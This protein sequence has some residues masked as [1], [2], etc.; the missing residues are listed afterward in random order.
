L[1]ASLGGPYSDENGGLPV[2]SLTARAWVSE[3]VAFTQPQP[4]SGGYAKDNAGAFTDAA[5]AVLGAPADFS[6]NA[7]TYHVAS[8]GNGGSIILAFPCAIHDGAG[9]DLAVFENGFTDES[10]TSGTVRE[11][12]TNSFAFAE[13]AFVDVGTTTS[14]WARFPVTCLNSSP[15]FNLNNL[16]EN[17]F[18]SQD[19]TLLDGIAGKHAFDRGTSFDL[20]DLSGDPAVLDGRVD[21]DNIRFVRL[22]DVVGDGSATDSE[23]RPIYDPFFSTSLGYPSPAAPSA[24]DGFDLRGVAVLN[25]TEIAI[26]TAPAG[27]EVVWHGAGKTLYQPQV[28]TDLMHWMDLGAAVTGFD[29]TLCVTSAMAGTQYHRVER[30]PVQP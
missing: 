10:D 28:S 12:A 19:V 3:V 5:S 13:L 17:R 8:L 23:G 26:R 9:P 11:G 15:V 16:G 14:A 29:N 20:S 24:T 30:R 21:L 18:A 27:C 6:L 4:E 22:T 25:S 1:A 2:T 7:V